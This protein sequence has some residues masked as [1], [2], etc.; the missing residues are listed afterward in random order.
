MFTSSRSV[1]L[2]LVIALAL[3]T[4]CSESASGEKTGGTAGVAAGMGGTAGTVNSGGAAGRTDPCASGQC[5]P[6]GFPFV[7]SS[8]AITDAC[9]DQ[10]CPLLAANTPVGETTASLSQPEP[11]IL[12]LSGTVSPAGWATLGVLFAVRNQDGTETLKK[13]D[14]DSL[15]ITQLQFSIDSPPSRG[16]SVHAAVTV[17]TSC[18]DDKFACVSD[19]F[20]LMTEPSGSV[21]VSIT[22][23]G[24]VSA[25]FANFVQPGGSQVFDT[26]ALDNLRFTVGPGDYDFC[27]HDFKFLDAQN[28]EILIP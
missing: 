10:G 20:S 12:C 21:P 15:G 27:V 11:G 1:P 19:D 9:V 22:S 18:P 8:R 7:S 24:P 6:Q 13:F 23:P 3:P 28:N 2:A 16:V 26:S 5:A 4:A 17:A 14:A 25:P